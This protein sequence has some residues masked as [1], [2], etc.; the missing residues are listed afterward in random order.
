MPRNLEKRV[1]ILFPIEREELKQ[2]VI[3]ILEMELLDNVKAHLLQADGTYEKVDR[4]GKVSINSQ[5]FF[6]EEAREKAMPV[7]AASV[8][9]VFVPETSPALD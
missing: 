1:E 7:E 9:R 4:R 2:E 5:D 3:H 6:A 8:S